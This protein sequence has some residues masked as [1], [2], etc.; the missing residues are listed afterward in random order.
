MLKKLTMLP[1]T[2]KV[3]QTLPKL[4][5]MPTLV[6]YRCADKDS[7]FMICL[8]SMNVAAKIGNVARNFFKLSDDIVNV[9][10]AIS[11]VSTKLM[12]LP[13]V[14]NLAMIPQTLTNVP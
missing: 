12:L 1:Q 6:I 10:K 4:A 3:P 11:Q 7:S 5:I 8:M 2:S 13:L 14:E 9:K